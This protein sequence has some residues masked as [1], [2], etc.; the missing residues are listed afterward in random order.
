M[1]IFLIKSEAL[2]VFKLSIFSLLSWFCFC[3]RIGGWV[4]PLREYLG[5]YHQTKDPLPANRHLVPQSALSVCYRTRVGQAVLPLYFFYPML[6]LSFTD[7]HLLSTIRNCWHKKR[8]MFFGLKQDSK[9]IDTQ[10]KCA[11]C[12]LDVLQ[13]IKSAAMA[14]Y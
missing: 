1:S 12:S 13:K 10:R 2:S 6:T 11:V 4:F 7:L 5:E 14:V 3:C 8:R 9:Y